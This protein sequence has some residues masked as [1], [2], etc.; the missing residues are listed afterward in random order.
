M[1]SEK[2]LR[3]SMPD[4][5]NTN[6][7]K[8][9]TPLQ[10]TSSYGIDTNLRLAHFLAQIGHETLSFLYYREIAS[11]LA[12]EGRKDLGNT[13]KGDGV[14]F[15]GRGCIQITG[16]A[17]YRECSLYLFG[18]TRLLDFPELLELPENGI[19]SACWF[20]NKKNLNYYADKDELLTIT[21]K[22]N[23]GT[24]GYGDRKRRLILAK[25]ALGI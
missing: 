16:R 24:N 22:I 6:L 9:L 23:G 20:W 1:I 17:N 11:G 2:Q 12:Y 5:T 7:V 19:K 8:Y 4:I 15:K 10:I 3:D 13:E 25:K 21:K 14:K 18:D